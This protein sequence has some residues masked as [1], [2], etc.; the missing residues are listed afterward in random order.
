MGFS[1]TSNRDKTSYD[2]N[3]YVADTLDDL[4][5]VPIDNS[6]GT[7]CIVLNPIGV[8]MLNTNKEWVEL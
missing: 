1:Q 2:V 3:Q 5:N 8:Y 7:T 4:K 6:P